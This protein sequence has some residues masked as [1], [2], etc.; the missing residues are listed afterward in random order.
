MF[1]DTALLQMGAGFSDSAGAIASRGADQFSSA[2]L[3][4]GIFGD[5]TEAEQF[6]KALSVAQTSHSETMRRHH[7]A[8]A[9]LADKAT[10][11]AKA[12]SEQDDHCASA[13]EAARRSFLI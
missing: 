5:F 13:L 11:A 1:V 6:R 7:L 8:L 3:P 4:V 9:K 2:A 12:F 10:T